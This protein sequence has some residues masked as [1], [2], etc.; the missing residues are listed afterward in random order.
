VQGREIVAVCTKRV[1]LRVGDCES[2]VGVRN[3]GF[4][5][6]FFAILHINFNPT[7]MN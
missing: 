6:F 4:F 3:I 2:L 1:A 7:V 5:F